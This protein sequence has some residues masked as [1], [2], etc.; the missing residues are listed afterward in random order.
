ML[1]DQLFRLVYS[2]YRKKGLAIEDDGV[3]YS[4]YHR[5]GPSWKEAGATVD[6]L[7]ICWDSKNARYTFRGGSTLPPAPR[8]ARL[9]WEIK[10]FDTTATLTIER[11]DEEIVNIGLA[12]PRVKGPQVPQPSL[13]V[14]SMK[15]KEGTLRASGK[16]ESFGT[17]TAAW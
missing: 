15:D 3:T 12:E 1:Q 5:D 2:V 16:N 14:Y 4:G 8:Y 6:K 10:D 9:I 11:Q 17:E 7:D 13:R